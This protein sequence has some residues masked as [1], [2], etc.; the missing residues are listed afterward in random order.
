MGEDVDIRYAL[1]VSCVR[2]TGTVTFTT[3]SLLAESQVVPEAV[4]ALDVI[5]GARNQVLHADAGRTSD[6]KM[7]FSFTED[8]R[9][10]SAG[11][12]S[13][14]QGGKI[15]LGV[16]GVGAAAAALAL[17]LPG[18]LVG[19]AALGAAEIARR[20]GLEAAPDEPEVEEPEV[21][22]P[23]LAAYAEEHKAAWELRQ[24]YTTLLEAVTEKI[25]DAGDQAVGATSDDDLAAAVTRLRLWR[26]VLPLLRAELELLNEHYRAW[27]A[28]K[29]HTR[30]E[31]HERI[32]TLDTLSSAAATVAPD[33]T[34]GFSADPSDA[35]AV[36]EVRS[37]WNRLGLLVTVDPLVRATPPSEATRTNKI[38]VRTPRRVTLDIFERTD[39]EKAVLQESRPHLVL[40]AASEDTEV[41][42][43]KKWLGESDVELTFAPSGALIGLGSKGTG[44]AAALAE[45]L[46]SLP[47]TISGGVTQAKSITD[48]VVGLRGTAA[49]QR[50]AQLDREVKTKQQELANAGLLATEGTHVELERLK[51]EAELLTQHKAIRDAT[52]GAP[53]AVADEIARLRQQVE[54][55]TQQR[56]VSV[57]A[58]Q[59]EAETALAEARLDLERRRGDS[60][61]R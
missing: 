47:E 36:A 10:T 6:T 18:A 19:G 51:R 7:S 21:E 59:L 1:P 20:E 30:T 39:D 3:D 57:A 17:G 24:R 45:T 9:L 37:V 8:G 25:A 15:I 27:R 13:A 46:G 40:D 44:A 61:T 54:L 5:A 41:E 29:I 34:V 60:S 31:T 53:D 58:R 56:E 32:L 28:T 22:D 52:P 12:S 14:G 16:A 4:A 35:P 48:A 50:L 2:A 38:L 33:G 11:V 43:P 42:L 23:E 55:L 26:S 49:D